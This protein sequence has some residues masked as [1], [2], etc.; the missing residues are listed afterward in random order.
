MCYFSKL[1]HIA[2]YKTKNQKTVKT[3]PR[4]HTH[5]HTHARTHARTHTRTHARTH[6]HTHTAGSDQANACTQRKN[7]DWEYQKKSVVGVVVVKTVTCSSLST[8]KTGV[9]PP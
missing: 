4:M 7:K 6:A 1:E 5:T 3:N 9:L 8:R 2:H